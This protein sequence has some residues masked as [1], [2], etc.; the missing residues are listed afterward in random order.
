[1][2]GEM[3]NNTGNKE[4]KGLS[5]RTW[6]MGNKNPRNLGWGRVPSGALVPT[7]KATCWPCFLVWILEEAGTCVGTSGPGSPR[8]QGL[9]GP[10]A[11]QRLG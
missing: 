8:G 5:K 10:G 6:M 9:A 1:M 2:A 4:G 3:N 11:G 7:G